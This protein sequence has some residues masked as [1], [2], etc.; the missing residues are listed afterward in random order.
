MPFALDSS[1]VCDDTSRDVILL[2]VP[3]V[4]VASMR[5][6]VLGKPENHTNGQNKNY[7]LQ[8]QLHRP[9]YIMYAAFNS[10]CTCLFRKLTW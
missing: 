1:P 10:F 5:F 6:L 4:E 7:R 8:G 3:L 9:C 2:P